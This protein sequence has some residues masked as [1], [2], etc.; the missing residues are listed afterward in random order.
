MH[1][2]ETTASGQD[3]RDLDRDAFATVLAARFGIVF[4]AAELDRLARAPRQ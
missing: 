3:A 2:I 1:L 4:E